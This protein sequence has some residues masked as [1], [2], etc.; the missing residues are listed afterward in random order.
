M[1]QHGDTHP[2]PTRVRLGRTPSLGR[3]LGLL[4]PL[5]AGLPGCGGSDGGATGARPPSVLSPPVAL[6]PVA[7][8]HRF[9]DVAAS[10]GI[11]ARHSLPAGELTNIVDSLGGGASFCDLDGDGWLDLIIASGA[12]SPLPEAQ[13]SDHG[14]LHVYRNLRNGRFE[15][16]GADCG[17][18]TDTTAVAIAV[19]DVDADGDLDVYLTDRGPNRL[20]LNQGDATFVESAAQAGVDDS[21]FGAAAAFFD[22]EGDGDLDL[23]V[24]NYLDYDPRET[25]YYAPTGFP[26]PLA[27]EAQADCLYRNLGDGRFEDVSV[28]SGIT[29]WKGRGMSIAT[30]DFDEDGHTDVFVANDAT[31]NF[32][33]INDGEGH[34]VERGLHAGVSLGNNGER[35]SAMAADLG[36][37]DGDG[38]LDLAVSDTAYGALYMR[39]RPG[40]FRDRSLPSGLGLMLGQYVSWGQNLLDY[41]DDGDLDLFIVN[42]GL[43]HLVGWQDVLALNDGTGRFEDAS[44]G[45]GEYFE[46]AQVGRCSIIGDY[47]ND[48]DLDVLVTTLAGGVSLLRNDRPGNAGWITLDLLG[49]TSRD[50]FGTRVEIEAGGRTQVAVQRCPTTYLGQNDPRVHFGLGD[51]VERVDRITITWPNGERQELSDVPARQILRVSGSAR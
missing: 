12:R 51:G 37:V 42:G 27:Y 11:Q 6:P 38:F 10:A 46:T 31:G 30:G 40:R 29:A 23:Y 33:W 39:T 1:Q 50:P 44:A 17:I 18:P 7:S 5:I 48:G 21:R 15:E 24:A 4:L 41:D 9:T 34:F 2:P 20:Y 26:G 16:L 13:P 35:T 3:T 25:A 8:E 43:H 14:G 28:S 22:M 45:A 36:D 32:L 19:A 47:D 49:P